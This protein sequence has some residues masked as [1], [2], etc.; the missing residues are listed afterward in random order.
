[1]SNELDVRGRKIRVK[2]I[3]GNE[4]FSLNDIATQ[5]GDGRPADKIFKWFSNHNTLGFLEAFEEENNP[6]CKP[7]ALK[8]FISEAKENHNAFRVEDF[9]KATNSPFVSARNKKDGAW[10]I[11]E[12]SSEFMMWIHVKF[13]VWFM[14]DYKRMKLEERK[15]LLDL[16][17]FYAQKNVDNLIK[18]LQHYCAG[19]VAAEE[20][21]GIIGV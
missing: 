3:K 16:E 5:F 13:K 1:M 21:D 12:I 9:E 2:K 18:A 6:K 17:G 19:N 15:S 20:L 10:A 14:K 4:M 7:R 8:K 11:F